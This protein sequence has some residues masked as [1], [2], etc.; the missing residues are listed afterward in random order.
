MSEISIGHSPDSDDAFMFYGFASG[1][2]KLE[3]H[4][5]RHVMEDIQALN[6]LSLTGELDI[7]A[8]SVAQYPEVAAQYQIMPCGASIGRNYGP[9][10]VSRGDVTELSDVVVGCPGE[11]TT[12]WL[13]YQVLAPA[14]REVKFMRFDKL[15]AALKAGEVDVAIMLHEKQVT[16]EESGLY[17]IVDLGQLWH[18]KYGLPLP[19]G[20][21]VVNRRLGADKIKE[22]TRAFRDSIQ[23]GF[24][25]EQAAL[26]YALTYAR[27]LSPEVAL[28]FIKMYVN[29]DT[30]EMGDEGR[31]ALRQIFALAAEKNLIDAAPPI[32]TVEI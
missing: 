5:I 22:L 32:D 2:V 31:A 20:I 18:D 11:K 6:V 10:V 7:T 4:T 26:E 9:I 12:S 17:K 21:D 16:Y 1:K 23:C 24:D 14:A 3:G 15:E 29:E 25:N 27:G 19:L 30:I 13:I 28:K 8:I